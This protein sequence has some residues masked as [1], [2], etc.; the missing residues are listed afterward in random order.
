MTGEA[1][2]LVA[3]PAAMRLGLDIETDRPVSPGFMR[4]FASAQRTLA[5][6]FPYDFRPVQLHADIRVPEPRTGGT[7][8]FFSGGVDSYFTALDR[9]SDIERLVLIHGFDINH[10]SPEL[11]AKVSGSIQ[12]AA[13]ELGRPIVE[14]DTDVRRFSDLYSQWG[15]HFHAMCLAAI[16]HLL[17]AATILVPSTRARTELVAWGSHPDLDPLLGG[18]AMQVVHHGLEAT[19]LEKIAAIATSD[20][21][22]RHL[23]VCYWNTDGAY[24]CGRCEKCTRTMLGLAACGKLGAARTFPDGIDASLI[25]S[26]KLHQRDARHYAVA[27][28][29][30]LRQQ[31]GN[32]RLV[33]AL[34]FALA[35]GW[36]AEVKNRT[37]THVKRRVR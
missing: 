2:A 12:S 27:N 22:L 34:R 4:D 37:I 23:R 10:E 19:R 25:R 36:A 24:N 14:I 20:T 18:E 9:L 13:S 17:G 35:R 1:Q 3:A 29:R 5:G 33:R 15:P 28:Y 30:G 26:L 21:A 6:W 11:R 31:R 32:A 16:G 8:S 7:V